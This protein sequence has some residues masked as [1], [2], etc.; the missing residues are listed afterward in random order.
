MDGS[1]P[2][3]RPAP[4]MPLTNQSRQCQ[5]SLWLVPGWA[6]DSTLATEASALSLGF[7][8]GGRGVFGA[9]LMGN[10]GCRG[11]RSEEA[12]GQDA[13]KN[14]FPIR[15]YSSPR[16]DSLEILLEKKI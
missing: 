12:Q 11:E 1:D 13:L 3:L 14:A 7:L 5:G 10:Q 16:E 15:A 9:A 8:T 4:G 6:G 2:I